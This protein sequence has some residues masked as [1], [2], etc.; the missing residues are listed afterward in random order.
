MTRDLRVSS[1]CNSA[2]GRLVKRAA[3]SGHLSVRCQRFNQKRTLII[4]TTVVVFPECLLHLADD[5]SFDIQEFGEVVRLVL[6]GDRLG[7]VAQAR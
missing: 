1:L 2:P 3:R 4:V 7:G 6:V 5:C